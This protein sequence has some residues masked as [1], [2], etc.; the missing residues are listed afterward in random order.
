MPLQA[1]GYQIDFDHWHDAVHG[2]LPYDRLLQR[3][4]KM[5]RFLQG[6]P[7]PKFIFTNADRKHADRCLGLMGVADLFEVPN[8]TIACVCPSQG[9]LTVPVC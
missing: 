4:E 9:L 7:L 3:D 5:R 1:N 2:T 6:I 8:P